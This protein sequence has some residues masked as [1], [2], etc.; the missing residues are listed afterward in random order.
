M[1]MM[2]VTMGI[3]LVMLGCRTRRR[4]RATMSMMVL[5]S[6]MVRGVIRAVMLMLV[7]GHRG[8]P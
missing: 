7:V 6:A 1:L 3:V 8:S 2:V 5:M 4:R